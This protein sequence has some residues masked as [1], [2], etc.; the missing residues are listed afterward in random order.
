MLKPKKAGSHQFLNLGVM[1]TKITWVVYESA[2]ILNN[3]SPANGPCKILK[4]IV[5][6]GKN[7][8]CSLQAA[9]N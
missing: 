6:P 2:G 9:K 5:R 3:K 4:I 8:Y 1:T 7:P